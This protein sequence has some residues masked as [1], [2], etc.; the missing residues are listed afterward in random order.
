MTSYWEMHGVYNYASV[1]DGLVYLPRRQ[2]SPE[3]LKLLL[4]IQWFCS[5]ES[6]LES[7]LCCQ[8]K[9]HL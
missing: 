2:C 1:F 3:C 8:V 7:N 9:V 5:S 6:V 4:F